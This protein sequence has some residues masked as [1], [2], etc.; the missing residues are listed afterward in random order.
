MV[1]RQREDLRIDG[2]SLRGS[3][4]LSDQFLRAPRRSGRIPAGGIEVGD[5]VLE[6]IKNFLDIFKGDK[7]HAEGG[8]TKDGLRVTHV[9]DRELGKR[10]KTEG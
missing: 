5:I 6:I 7:A 9:V 10:W 2:E 3:F 4:A 8:S 1:W